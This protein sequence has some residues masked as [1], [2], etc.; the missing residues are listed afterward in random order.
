LAKSSSL[1]VVDEDFAGAEPTPTDEAQKIGCV[2]DRPVASGH[3]RQITKLGAWEVFD[4]VD[5]AIARAISYGIITQ[6]CSVRFCAYQAS[7]QHEGCGC[8]G[9]QKAPCELPIWRTDASDGDMRQLRSIPRLCLDL[10]VM[11]PGIAVV[12]GLGTIT[13][14]IMG[15]QDDVVTGVLVMAA[16]NP[17]VPGNNRACAFA[18][19]S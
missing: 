3:R 8:P 5:M 18:M 17:D 11:G 4:A 7:G 14:M 10:P 2:V 19:P 1:N 13:M 15:R 12:I 9:V 16:M 6:L